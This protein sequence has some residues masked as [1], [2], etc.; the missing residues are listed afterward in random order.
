MKPL[1]KLCAASLV[2]MFALPTA[3]TA[4]SLEVVVK[5]VNGAVVTVQ[6]E[7]TLPIWL[8]NDTRVL[9]AG[10][11]STVKLAEGNTFELQFQTSQ[12]DALAPE[13]PLTIHHQSFGESDGLTCG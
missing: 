7:S 13:T 5:E 11:D 8:Q 10:W 12:S 6:S 9:A 2:F 1:T 3:A 4:Q